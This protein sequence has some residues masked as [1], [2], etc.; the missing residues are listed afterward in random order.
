MR[1]MVDKNRVYLGFTLIELLVVISII[2]LLVGILLPALGAARKSAQNLKCA[3]NMRQLGIAF[4]GYAT[5]NGGKF[6]LH[7]SGIPATW[8]YQDDVIGAYV[9]GDIKTGSNS[10]GGL[11]LPCPSDVEGASRS[12]TM[13]I[14][15]SSNPTPASWLMPPSSGVQWDTGSPNQSSLMLVVEA[16]SIYPYEGQWFTRASLGGENFTP[17]QHFVAR[18]EPIIYPDRGI[19]ALPPSR[20]DYNRHSTAGTPFDAEGSANFLYADGHVS[21]RGDTDLVD[22]TTQ[23]ST[24]DSLWTPIDEKVENP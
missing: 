6:P 9:P 18:S 20:I 12:Y 5:D 23:K 22:R 21:M 4:M 17:Y 15:A 11:I 13:N 8:W 19:G 16:W 10:I 7:D 24:Y 14:W 2:A 3:S 1:Q